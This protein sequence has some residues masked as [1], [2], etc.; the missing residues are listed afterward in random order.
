ME[1]TGLVRYTFL[2][3]AVILYGC[4]GN[5]IQEDYAEVTISF[6]KQGFATKALDPDEN[7][8]SDISLLVYDSNGLLEESIWCRKEDLT[9]G[10]SMNLLC[11][12][13]YRFLACVNFGYRVASP[14][15]NDVLEQRFY[16]A[17]PDEYKEGIPMTADSGLIYIDKDSQVSLSLKRLMSKISVRMDR[18]K[19]SDDV[20][21]IVRSVKIGNCPKSVTAFGE[22]RISSPDECFS[23]GFIRDAE[24]CTP[25]NRMAET[26]ISKEISVYMFENMQGPF[27]KTG[28]TEDS[29]KVFDK[30]DPRRELCSYIEICMDYFSTDWKSI[31]TGLIYRFYL[32][33][34][35]NNLDIERNYHYRITICPED[36]GLSEDSWRVDKSNIEP[37]G[38]VSFTRWPESYIR[39]DIGDRIHIGCTFTPSY[40]PFDVGL[41]YMMDDKEAGIYDYEIDEDGHGA[42]LTLT[43]PGRGLIYMEVGE[44]VNEAALWIIEVNLPGGMQQYETPYISQGP[45]DGQQRQ[46]YRH[47]RQLPDQDL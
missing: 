19:L 47:H 5:L 38:P 16:L 25:L 11:G 43:G 9:A 28:I 15:I 45:Q 31:D 13:D 39:G 26:G 6:E 40:A 24:E 22:S 21:M 8:V 35:R 2:S 4:T 17:Y 10:I 20:E 14:D 44:P 1:R 18:R 42:I 46:D 33:E 7:L 34:N 37:T 27:C 30:N 12:K 41:E 23:T 3:L 36:D 29:E 32:G